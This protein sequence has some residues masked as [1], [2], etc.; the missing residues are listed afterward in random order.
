[1]SLI[2]IPPDVAVLNCGA[3][4]MTFSFDE[5]NP[6]ELAKAQR[7]VG[8][9]LKRGYLLFARVGDGKLKRV[10]KFNPKTNEYTITDGA[11]VEPTVENAPKKSG[12]KK[13][14]TKTV[15][16]KGTPVTGIAPTSGG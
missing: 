8:D 6:E 1:M 11:E 2:A 7:V 10:K 3:G 13:T 4:D 12:R 15:K 14:K 5:A 9:M 16:A